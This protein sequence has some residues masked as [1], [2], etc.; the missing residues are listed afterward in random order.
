[1]NQKNPEKVLQA[2]KAT[3]TSRLNIRSEPT[4]KGEIFGVVNKSIQLAYDGYTIEGENISGNSKWYFTQE[5]S[6]FWSGGVNDTISISAMKLGEKIPNKAEGGTVGP[7]VKKITRDSVKFK[8]LISYQNDNVIFKNEEGTGADRMMTPRLAQKVDELAK[9]V[10]AEWNSK[11]KLRITEAWDE[12][13]EHAP[14]SIHYEARAADITTSDRDPAKL[15]RLGALAVQAG[16]DWVFYE[17]TFH[18]H[19]SVSREPML[20]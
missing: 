18:V 14:N 7:I 6:W 10:L 4:K 1:M 17:N 2:G 8:T 19:V 20:V 13:I 16:F 15:G 5:G 11:T 9:L 12:N 3:T